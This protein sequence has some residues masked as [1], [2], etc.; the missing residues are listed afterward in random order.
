[1]SA[2]GYVTPQEAEEAFYANL[3]NLDKVA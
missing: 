3:S 1:H 2:I